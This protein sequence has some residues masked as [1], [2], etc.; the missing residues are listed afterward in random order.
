M[1][2]S[3]DGQYL[4]AG[5]VVF[6]LKNKRG[7]CLESD[8]NG[9][10]IAVASIRNGGT[11]YGAVQES[12]TADVTA[13]AQLDL[14]TPT[15]EAKVLETGTDVPLLHT[16]DGAAVFLTRNGDKGLTLAVRRPA[17]HS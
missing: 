1:V 10:T 7:I 15:G 12:E 3:P 16:A 8:G 6:D 2:S 5:S 13:A 4:A 17:A 11:A 9:K 14:N